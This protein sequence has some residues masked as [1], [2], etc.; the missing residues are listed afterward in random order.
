M[1][2]T[3]DEKLVVEEKPSILLTKSSLD[4]GVLVSPQQAVDLPTE[5]VETI[6]G[7]I[8]PKTQEAEEKV[9]ESLARSV[10]ELRPMMAGVRLYLSCQFPHIDCFIQESV[11][12]DTTSPSVQERK[13][14]SESASVKQN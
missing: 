9:S 13:V 3:L 8:S 4:Q 1:I 12:S 14:S 11:P 2:K 10:G 6:E 5:K 7:L